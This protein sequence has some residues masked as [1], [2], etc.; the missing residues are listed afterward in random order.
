M[1]YTGGTITAASF[2]YYS[3]PA[4]GSGPFHSAAHINAT[5]DGG[6]GSAWISAIPEPCAGLYGLLT[7][8]LC[9]RRR[10]TTG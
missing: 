5:P 9:Q 2:S 1:T 8:V 4:G 7:L 6:S 3:N 10:R